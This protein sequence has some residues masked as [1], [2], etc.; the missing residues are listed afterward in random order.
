M[1]RIY[2]CIAMRR[3]VIMKTKLNWK[4][5]GRFVSVLVQL[6][7][8]ITGVFKKAK[9]G[10]EVID[11]LL[12]SGKNFFVGKLDE[13]VA[14]FVKQNPSELPKKTDETLLNRLVKVDRTRTPQ[15]VLDATGRK[16]YTDNDVVATMPRGT[17]EEVKIVFFKLGRYI[18]DVDLD[19]EYE[20]RGLKPADPYS[21]AAVNEDDP[22]FADEHPNATHWKDADGNWCHAAFRLWHVERGVGVYRYGLGWY[23]YWWFAG[24]AS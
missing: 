8:I 1:S 14:E 18:S 5:I 13:I 22:A 20:S 12:G 17:D 3:L 19:K 24:L 21:L 2:L 11:W 23:D 4:E 16:Q 6:F 10:P 9:V 7:T 15:A